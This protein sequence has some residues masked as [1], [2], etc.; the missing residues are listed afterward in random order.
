MPNEN[1]CAACFIALTGCRMPVNFLYFECR[2]TRKLDL[3]PYRVCPLNKH[4][5]TKGPLDPI[6][7]SPRTNPKPISLSRRPTLNG[8]V[9]RVTTHFPF[10]IFSITPHI[11]IVKMLQF[12]LGLQ[13][14]FVSS[15]CVESTP[16]YAVGV[17]GKWNG[18]D[19]AARFS[20]YTDFG[21]QMEQTVEME[22]AVPSPATDGV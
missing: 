9:F 4:T 22:V 11:F 13:Q 2:T 16:K 21:G 1:T 8:R 14:I 6:Q 7:A 10:C 15:F 19:L 12:H 5:I 18:T 17:G 3:S 20:L